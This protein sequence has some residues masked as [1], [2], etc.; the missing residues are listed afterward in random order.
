[1]GYMSDEE[2]SWL[3]ISS[4]TEL[5]ELIEEYGFHAVVV[6]LNNPYF[7]EDDTADKTAQLLYL[8]SRVFE[9]IATIIIDNHSLLASLPAG[10]IMYTVDRYDQNWWG[11][12]GEEFLNSGELYGDKLHT[13]CSRLDSFVR[14]N[15]VNH[16]TNVELLYVLQAVSLE[17]HGPDSNKYVLEFLAGVASNPN[18]PGNLA[19]EALE[20]SKGNHIMKNGNS[21][22]LSLLQNF[23][24]ARNSKDTEKILAMLLDS[25]DHEKEIFVLLLHRQIPASF[26]AKILAKQYLPSL[27]TQRIEHDERR[28]IDPVIEI[29]QGQLYEEAVHLLPDEGDLHSLPL[30]WV[31]ES[32]ATE[33]REGYRYVLDW[34]HK[35]GSLK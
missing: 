27:F 28:L 31:I 8:N 13:V 14:A 32:V 23:N 30:E 22:E 17:N 24:F 3:D 33:N 6:L 5:A 35:W 16:A 4:P 1:M 10:F 19:L 11:R 18:C 12:T 15:L 34:V 7:L 20:A 9:D 2:T 26:K 29:L 21:I 25:I